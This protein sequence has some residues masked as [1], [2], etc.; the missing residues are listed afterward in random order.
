MEPKPPRAVL[1]A[2]LLP[3]VETRLDCTE[4]R[5]A[6]VDEDELKIGR[7]QWVPL[8][9]PDDQRDVRQ[10]CAAGVTPCTSVP[11]MTRAPGAV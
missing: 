11:E 2:T 10:G 7:D 3:G 8:P 9:V 1:G 6:V 5:V 4:V